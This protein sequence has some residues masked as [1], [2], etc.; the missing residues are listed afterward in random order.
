MTKKT[1]HLGPL[2]VVLALFWS[3]AGASPKGIHAEK[4]PCTRCHRTTPGPNDTLKTA[5]LVMPAKEL[6]AGCHKR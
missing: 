4:F 1:S 3:P 2:L 5:P 6:C